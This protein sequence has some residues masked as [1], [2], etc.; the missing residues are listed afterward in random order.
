M[1]I[2]QHVKPDDAGLYTCVA[3]TSSGK[4]SCSAELNVQ[5]MV[6][7]LSREPVKPTFVKEL[8]NIKV[9]EGE[10]VAILEAQISGYPKPRL[11]WF[12]ED[13]LIKSSEKYKMLYEGEENYALLIKN[14]K[15]DDA[16][17]YKLKATNELG[18]VESEAELTVVKKPKLTKMPDKIE[19]GENEKL[20]I[21]A[22]YESVPKPEVKWSKDGVELKDSK[23]LKTAIKDDKI[24]LVVEKAT[25]E[26]EGKYQC[27]V[28]N[29][30]GKTVG[31]VDVAVRGKEILHH[32]NDNNANEY[33]IYSTSKVL[34]ENGRSPYL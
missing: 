20:V 21:Q 17:N 34:E 22:T 18:Y 30:L 23:R 27:M 32:K 4:I 26:D 13:Q 31:D 5:G 11:E 33:V 16:G 6:R 14:V 15:D 28:S 2:F 29:E 25:A 1:L 3:S 10:S 19:V 7:E 8:S 9:S 12:K 24:E